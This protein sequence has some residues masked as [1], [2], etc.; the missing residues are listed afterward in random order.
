MEIQERLCVTG[1]IV[2]FSVKGK[3]DVRAHQNSTLSISLF[4]LDVCERMR[5]TGTEL[6][7][8]GRLIIRV[9]EKLPAGP[10]QTYGDQ[11]IICANHTL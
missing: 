4:D 7:L 5:R 2:H 6:C 3:E 9:R 8:S 1:M 10:C 11:E